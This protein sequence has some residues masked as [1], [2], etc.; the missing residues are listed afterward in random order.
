M[1]QAIF[2]GKERIGR[3]TIER[4]RDSLRLRWT[5]QGKTFS[6][7]IGKDCKDTLKVAKAKAQTHR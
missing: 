1:A 2:T 6:L 3:V 5:L 7:M 4:F